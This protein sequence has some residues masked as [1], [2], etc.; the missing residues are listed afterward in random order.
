MKVNNFIGLKDD[1]RTVKLTEIIFK[2]PKELNFATKFLSFRKKSLERKLS[3]KSIR[4]GYKN[5]DDIKSAHKT[6]IRK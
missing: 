3:H 5:Q 6:L 1:K 4:F 2:T